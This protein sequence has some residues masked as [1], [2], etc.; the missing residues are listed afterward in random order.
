MKILW[1]AQNTEGKC[2]NQ[3]YHYEEQAW[4]RHPDVEVTFWG[5]GRPPVGDLVFSP[6]VPICQVEDVV[7]P[8]LV[9]VGEWYLCG[10]LGSFQGVRAPVAALITDNYAQTV[11]PRI[12]KWRE[13][14]VRIVLHRYH[15][16]IADVQALMPG[17][18][19]VWN[20]WGAETSVFQPGDGPRRVN[21]TLIGAQYPHIYPIRAKAHAALS[22]RPDLGYTHA[23]H[24]SYFRPGRGKQTQSSVIGQGYAELFARSKIAIADG[25]EIRYP[26][27][28]YFEIPACGTVLLADWWP[29]LSEFGFEPDVN[30]VKIEPERVCQQVAD[31]LDHDRWREIAGA[32]LDL[33]LTR[34]TWRHRVGSAL[35]QLRRYLRT[36]S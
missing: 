34:H 4:V 30:M 36:S 5:S 8:D 24:P 18:C 25:G 21:V 11:L 6:L 27:G 17:A 10:D 16:G 31:L 7:K 33:V 20:P 29:G 3:N 32:G 22:A 12:S 26:V 23:P 13:W 15:E 14:G 19:F 9:M 28:K 1:C 35:P 2:W